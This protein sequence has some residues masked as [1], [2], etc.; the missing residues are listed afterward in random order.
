MRDVCGHALRSGV[1]TNTLCVREKKSPTTYGPVTID[2]IVTPC[3]THKFPLQ[4]PKR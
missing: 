3:Y 4:N 1:M 2:T